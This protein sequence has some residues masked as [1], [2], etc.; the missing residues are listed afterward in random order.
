M[1][2][3]IEEKETA[4]RRSFVTAASTQ[5]DKGANGSSAV[6]HLFPMLP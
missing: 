3:L 6:E 5:D 4:A 2:L 1:R